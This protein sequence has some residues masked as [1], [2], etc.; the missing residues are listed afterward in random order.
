MIKTT[1]KAIAWA[2]IVAGA[3]NTF[4]TAWLI[5]CAHAQQSAT[6]ALQKARVFERLAEGMAFERRGTLV[7]TLNARP[8]FTSYPARLCSLFF[9]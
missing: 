5:P 1:F 2:A 4:N 7:G 9:L 6:E 3:L 8:A